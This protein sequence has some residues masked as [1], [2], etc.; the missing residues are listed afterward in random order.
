VNIHSPWDIISG[1]LDY[2]DRPDRSN[3]HAVENISDKDATTLLAAHVEY[4][5]NDLLFETIVEALQ[6]FPATAPR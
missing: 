1:K 4:W 3:R 6:A 5:R 2:Y